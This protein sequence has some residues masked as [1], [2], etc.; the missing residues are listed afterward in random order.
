MGRHRR[1]LTSLIIV[2]ASTASAC[3]LSPAEEELDGAD[4]DCPADASADPVALEPNVIVELESDGATHVLCPVAYAATPPTS[5]DHFPAWQNCGF[6]TEPVR[7]EAA[8]HSLEHGAI[9]IAYDPDIG[10]ERLDEIAAFV[11]LD[12]HFM[13][14]P[15]P[16]LQ[17]PIVL[18]AWQRQLAVDSLA[19]PVVE[20]FV[21][22]LLSRVSETA[23]EAGAPCDRGIGAAPTDVDLGYL[24]AFEFFSNN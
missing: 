21:D 22:R 18:S 12:G 1:V 2:F 9:W 16:G 20:E 24:D 15:Y 6:Y 8:V 17:N 5:G 19:E 11:E 10:Q 4:G 23:P 7:N 14:S 3:G 13:A